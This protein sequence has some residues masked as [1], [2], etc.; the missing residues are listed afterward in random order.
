[1]PLFKCLSSSETFSKQNLGKPRW[2]LSWSEL[3]FQ[4]HICT[5]HLNF[6]EIKQ[7]I[8]LRSALYCEMLRYLRCT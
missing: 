6:L 7:I 2:F 8:K 3:F 1:M 4:I 5:W